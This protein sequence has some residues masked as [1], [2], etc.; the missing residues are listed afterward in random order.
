[1]SD[2]IRKSDV[3]DSEF[4]DAV[5][6]AS[7]GYT[8]SST[9]YR[10]VTLVSTTAATKR[11]V[12]TSAGVLDRLDNV[13]EPLQVG[14]IVVIAGNAAAGTYTCASIVDA[15]TFTV[16]EA[17]ANSAGGTAD[18]YHPAGALKVGI[19]NTNISFTTSDNVQGA[20][21]DVASG[22]VLPT[23]AQE[24]NVLFA[25]IQ[26]VNPLQFRVAQPVTSNA[27]WLV[28]DQ[29]ILLVLPE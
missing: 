10:T 13:D 16:V 5:E 7:D 23:P 29:G 15:T 20:L 2:T 22:V 8:A 12:I 1:M 26:S 24:G 9:P 17:I 14:D 6:L 28:N 21:E 19:D 25:F 11:V 4:V 3:Y 27:G 18:F